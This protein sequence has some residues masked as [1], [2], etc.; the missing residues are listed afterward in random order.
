[1]KKIKL[2]LLSIVM[3]LCLAF[4]GVSIAMADNTAPAPIKAKVTAYDM[5]AGGGG[6]AWQANAE[7]QYCVLT[8]SLNMNTGETNNV[9]I[10]FTAPASGV[11]SFADNGSSIKIASGA[12][13]GAR[14]RLI[15]NDT[16][17]YPT[18]ARWA[19]LSNDGTAV[20]LKPDDFEMSA[21]DKL[22]LVFDNGGNFS[23][24]SDSIWYCLGFKLAGNWFGSNEYWYTDATSGAVEV[25]F[26]GVTVAK[27]ALIKYKYGFVSDS[28]QG[29]AMD[30]SSATSTDM[31]VLVGTTYDGVDRF[32]GDE[33]QY[34]QFEKIGMNI[35]A[36]TPNIIAMEMTADGLFNF[37]NSY[38]KSFSHAANIEVIKNDKVV[39]TSSVDGVLSTIDNMQAVSVAEGDVIY[40]RL[41]AADG[42]YLRYAL[43]G[44]LTTANGVVSYSTLD[45]VANAGGNCIFYTSKKPEPMGDVTTAQLKTLEGVNVE[46]MY[47]TN[48]KWTGSEEF[49]LI[50]KEASG[51][52]IHTGAS[53]NPAIAYEFSAS[54]IAKIAGLALTVESEMS[55][56]V[57]YRVIKKTAG[58]TDVY[59]QLYPLDGEWATQT[60]GME[61]NLSTEI[62]S[63][64][65]GDQLILVVNQNGTNSLDQ[66]DVKFDVVFQETDKKAQSF[67]VVS[68]FDTV[69]TGAWKYVDATIAADYSS[70]VVGDVAN[71]TYSSLEKNRIILE[72]MTYF[73][74]LNRWGIAGKAFLQIES[75][76]MHP[77]A[78]YA[79]AIGIKMPEAGRV[80]MS[81]TT[82]KYDMHSTPDGEGHVSDG[83]RIR[84]L[85]NEDVIYPVNGGWQEINDS[86]EKKYDIPVFEV[87]KD[88]MIYVIVDCGAAGKENYDLTYVS[89]IAH[90]AEDGTNWTNT[91]DSKAGFL[92]TDKNYDAFSY[93]SYYYDM[94]SSGDGS[95]DG[96]GDGNGNGNSDGNGGGNTDTPVIE[97]E[98]GG[99]GSNVGVNA[100]FI[101]LSV[102]VLATAVVCLSKKRS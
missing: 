51:V 6:F 59:Q 69:N 12:G 98:K 49:S 76:S 80:D 40:V 21:G 53:F 1:M 35:M 86:A 18:D 101:V 20:V 14:V 52:K 75:G 47:Y 28:L 100:S 13:D 64:V 57:R 82:F 81:D 50:W 74:T 30:E 41:T 38:F 11:A 96:N 2:L 91:F 56:G 5:T 43:N 70:T 97:V 60:F 25:D 33:N 93:W 44:V 55:D 31:E 37:Q 88:D 58:D 27:S 65:A 73:S 10:E 23:N 68:G 67:N 72:E 48:N 94:S 16:Q 46:N 3:I 85:R 32:K 7:D 89:I 99:C 90:F 15:H 29:V 34:C 9:I 83:V 54:G 8:D 19:D 36:G 63:V 42:A 71:N 45:T 77:N 24:A 87:E 92:E 84:I 79:A 39:Y 4:G 66:T 61:M 102:L 26:A 22:Y 78:I 62:V 95:G 17:V